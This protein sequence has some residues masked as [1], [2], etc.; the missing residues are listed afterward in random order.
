[1]SCLVALVV[2]VVLVVA[3]GGVDGLA[4]LERQLARLAVGVETGRVAA[5]QVL[6]EHLKILA[7]ERRDVMVVADQRLRLQAMDQIV[8]LAQ[9]PVHAG[10]FRDPR[11]ASLICWSHQPSN[12]MPAIGP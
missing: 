5:G 10:C 11:P 9:V 6:F 8:R 2:L 1:M 12:Q 4:G 3:P 7:G